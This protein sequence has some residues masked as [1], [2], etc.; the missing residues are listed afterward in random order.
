MGVRERRRGRILT[1]SP[2]S[3][4]VQDPTDRPDDALVYHGEPLKVLG[5]YKR[6]G[7]EYARLGGYLVKFS[8]PTDPDLVGDYF[9]S[10][11]DFG[12]LTRKGR[13]EV[14]GYYQ[15]G[16]DPHFKG[17]AIGDADLTADAFGVWA[18]YQIEIRSEYER[19]LVEMAR[20][21]KM[22]QSSGA[23]GHLVDRKAVPSK[24]GRVHEITRWPI[25]E[26]SLTPTPAEP[27]TSAVPLK[28]FKEW[29]QKQ[30]PE[31]SGFGALGE[32]VERFES[33]MERIIATTQ[34]PEEG[35]TMENETKATEA[36]QTPAPAEVKTEQ[37][38]GS[39][40][41]TLDQIRAEMTE[42]FKAFREDAKPS[43]PA[44]LNTKSG[45]PAVLTTGRGDTEAKAFKA[46]ASGDD[47]AM[48]HALVGPNLVEIKASNNTDMN[49]GTA[50][51]GGNA[52]PT[53]HFNGII[54]RRD[55]SRLNVGV[56]DIPG[57]GTTVNV[58][59][60]AEDDGE[61][62]STAEA[63]ANDRDAPAIGQVAMTLVKYTKRIE[64]SDELLQD[65]E[66]RLMAFIEDF[67]GR[68]MAKTHND[69]LVTEVE[70]NG[71]ALKTTASTTALA[72]GELED[73]VYGNN[74]AHYLG[75]GAGGGDWVMQPLTYS[76]V[77]QL[78]GSD[79]LYAAQAQGSA[80]GPSILGYGVNFSNKVEAYGTLSNK[81]ALFGNFGYVGRRE[82]PSFQVLRDPYSA[83]TTGQLRLHYFFRTVYK[84][85][86]SEAVGYLA[87]AA[88]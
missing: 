12:T 78:T 28:A 80:S 14:P 69:L 48:K 55:E 67:I 75:E 24:G 70:T 72:A 32:I 81:F 46:W 54:A 19:H 2:H 34:A 42:Q 47:G 25:G 22:G 21:G 8:G 53:G 26:A 49:I 18:E 71:S 3:A 86:Q 5:T 79:R 61:F 15:H 16:F 52:V 56:R 10:D 85:L 27:R 33:T 7:T 1:L 29:A 44:A 17:E 57:V 84:V 37:K 39:A 87:H 41:L 11:T 13:A 65:E 66:S 9:T 73:A 59:V 38:D 88:A 60:D 45:A 36:P 35:P 23:V 63:A 62:V 6:A 82:E 58:P 40:V 31:S 77:L 30:A 74:I 51:D 43:A 83:A 20:E 64:L 76:K 68:G 50:A 4:R